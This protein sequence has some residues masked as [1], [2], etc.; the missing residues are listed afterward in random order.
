[1]Q[2]F[3]EEAATALTDLE[4]EVNRAIQWISCDLKEYWTQ[5]V[6]KAQEQVAEARITLERKQMFR[7]GEERPSCIEEK[8]ALEAAKRRL[9][10][11]QQK[12]EAVRRW[13]QVLAREF[14]EYKGRVAVLSGWLQTDLPKGLAVL[15]SMAGALETYVQMD[16]AAAGVQGASDSS[17]EAGGTPQEGPAAPQAS[18][19]AKPGGGTTGTGLE[20]GGVD[21][22]R[23]PGS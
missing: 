21:K 1:L 13:S 9:Q 10:L 16:A 14:M 17:A 15:K 8:K 22:G 19:A 6:R 23:E 20:K 4:L 5:Q 2:K 18:P 11:C 3:G 7:A 12:L